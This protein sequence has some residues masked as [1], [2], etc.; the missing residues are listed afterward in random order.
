MNHRLSA[1]VAIVCS[2]SLASCIHLNSAPTTHA[3]HGHDGFKHLSADQR[4]AA[5]RH[6]RIWMPT[7]VAAMN[8]KQGP[9]VPGAFPPNSTVH[10]RF[11]DRKMNGDTPK[12]TCEIQP[13]ED[14]KVKFG[15]ENGEVYAE[16][17]ATR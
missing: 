12:F 14:L 17:A 9:Q 13:G 6:A 8:L 3:K 16:V 7:R 15:P 10:C 1:T 4:L 5:I 2:A 11:V